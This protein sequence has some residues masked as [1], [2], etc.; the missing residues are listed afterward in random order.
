MT[1]LSKPIES[2]TDKW[3]FT[4][5]K[6]IR[7]GEENEKVTIFV[8]IIS[9]WLIKPL[10]WQVSGNPI[11]PEELQ[12]RI[13]KSSWCR[14]RWERADRGAQKVPEN[15]YQQFQKHP[16]WPEGNPWRLQTE[17]IWKNSLSLL[18]WTIITYTCMNN[19]FL[20]AFSK[21]RT[22]YQVMAKMLSEFW[23]L[24]QAVTHLKMRVF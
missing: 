22:L 7:M 16:R 4:Q 19:N 6:Q 10:Y 21:L 24:T 15:S 14:G 9:I 23:L 12:W 20:F 8:K 11:F 1:L 13:A 3:S 2:Q 17:E 5:H 18:R